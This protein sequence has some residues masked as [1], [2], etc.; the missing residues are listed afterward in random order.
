MG[1]IFILPSMEIFAIVMALVVSVTVGRYTFRWT[2]ADL[3]DFWDCVKFSL[4]PDLF[5]MFR[6]QFFEDMTQSFKLS[7]Y[8][9]LTFGSGVLVYWAIT[10]R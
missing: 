2:F 10:G 1:M 4:T 8:L 3:D 5:S 6:G 7:A 9:L